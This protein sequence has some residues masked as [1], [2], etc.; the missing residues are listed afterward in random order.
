MAGQRLYF[1]PKR[2]ISANCGISI[3]QNR[4]QIKRRNRK[5]F[6]YRKNNPDLSLEEIGEK[7]NLTKQSISKILR[8]VNGTATS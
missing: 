2:V 1:T 5:I 6:T 3:K 8:G 7:F 4:A